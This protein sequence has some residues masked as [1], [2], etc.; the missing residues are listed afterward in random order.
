MIHSAL[1]H[2]KRALKRTL[3]ACGLG[4]PLRAIQ[5]RVLHVP[6]INSPPSLGPEFDRTRISIAVQAEMTRAAIAHETD[7][8]RAVVSMHA[9]SLAAALAEQSEQARSLLFD[10]IEGY[11]SENRFAVGLT[12]HDVGDSEQNA[13]GALD[14]LHQKLQSPLTAAEIIGACKVICTQLPQPEKVRE[15][16]EA[17]RRDSFGPAAVRSRLDEWNEQTGK[18]AKIA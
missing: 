11:H 18:R 2:G 1:R 6:Q 9:A 14:A 12:G 5:R 3:K 10:L 17:H 13:R 16:L 15:L 8:I 4:P 7:L